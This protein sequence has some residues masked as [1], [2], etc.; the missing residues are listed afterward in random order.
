[1]DILGMTVD[2]LAAE[3]A[4][5]YG[6][7]RY[8]AAA[9]CREIH[10]NGNP[11][12]RRA[13]AFRASPRLTRRLLQDLDLNP[14]QVLRMQTEGDLV[15]LAVGL[16]DGE[17][18]ESVIIPMAGRTTLCISSQAGCRMGCRFCE[19]GRMG[20]RRNLT[21]G[22]IVGQVY[23]ARSVLGYPVGNVVFMGMGEPLDN[24]GPVR[25]AVRVLSGDHGFNLARRRITL[26]TAG[27]VD[28]IR[29]LA[30]PDGPSPRLAVSLNAPNDRIRSRIMPVNRVHPMADLRRALL[31]YP[32]DPKGAIFVEYVLMEGVNDRAE[33]ADELAGFLSPLRVKVNLIPCNPRSDGPFRPPA[34]GAA[35][36]FRE[37]LTR[38]KIF[39]RGR[40]IKGRN[41]MAACGQLGGKL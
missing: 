19:T 34:P 8:H 3:M 6:K 4:A 41:V 40:A 16:R 2:D 5:R 28:G 13:D 26:S 25:Q 11:D 12:W 38:H 35:E 39:V 14:G 27:L 21:A 30:D 37:R 24:F 33:H 17:T 36:G 23:L 20:L 7:G 22:E 29:R 9:L 1:V 15:K 31:A 18:V 32:L 10:R